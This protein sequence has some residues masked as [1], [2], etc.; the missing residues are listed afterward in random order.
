M[1]KK[2]RVEPAVSTQAENTPLPRFVVLDETYGWMENG[3]TMM[4]KEGQIVRDPSIVKVL[5]D[6]GAPLL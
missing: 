5:I 6:R 3:C 4:F 2:S 1:A